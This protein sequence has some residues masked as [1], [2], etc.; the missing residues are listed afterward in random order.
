MKPESPWDGLAVPPAGALDARRA[1]AS[2]PYA[3]FYARNAQGDFML[4]LQVECGGGEVDSLPSLRGVE[5][6][7]LPSQGR[8]QLRLCS[9]SD[10]DMF[11]VLCRDLLA[12][13]TGARSDEECIERTLARLSRW[14]RLLSRGQTKLL[15]EEQ[16]RGLFAELLFLRDELMPRFGPTAVSA[17]KGP[18]GYPQDFAIDGLAIEVK[19]HLVGSP[20]Q[21]RISSPE[22]L[23]AQGAELY[24]RVQRLAVA[25]AGGMNLVSLVGDIA[26]SLEEHPAELA[27]LELSLSE[28]GYNDAPE[29]VAYKLSA[30]GMDTYLVHGDFPRIVPTAVPEGTC[31]VTY[32]IRLPA[33]TKYRAEINWNGERGQA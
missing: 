15:N 25:S 14:Q 16:I 11:A 5:V 23:H 28:V 32:S 21:V 3:F 19:S 29:Y 10:R 6:L 1:D 24:L 20:A 7:W 12:S 27:S 9:A 31:S 13:T 18:Q 26:Q 22:Q 8:L 4:T 2:H 30:E 17:W 33:L